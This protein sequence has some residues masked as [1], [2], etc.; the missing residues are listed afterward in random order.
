[1]ATATEDISDDD[2]GHLGLHPRCG[3]C[4]DTISRHERV[5][6]LFGNHYS[7]SYRGR[8][9]IFAFA[10][11]GHT[12]TRVNGCLL[13]RYPDSRRCAAS[14]EF[15]PIHFDCF[16]IFRQQCSVSASVAMQR[17]WIVASWRNPWRGARPVHLTAPMVDKD[18]LGTISGFCGLPRLCTLP[19]E[20]LEMIRQ[21]SEHS[22]LWRCIPALQL[23]D[24]VSATEPEPLLTVPLQEVHFW[25]RG[26]KLILDSDG[27]SKVERLPGP[28]SYTGECTSR[29][30]FIVQ[31]EASVSQ[32]VVRLKDGRL[33]L[34]R[35]AGLRTLLIWNTPAPPSLA[36]CKAYPADLPSCH[37]IHAVEMDAM[38]GIT[39]F[40]SGGQLFGIHPHRRSEESCG[41][42]TFD[43][44][45]PNRLRRALLAGDVI[46]GLQPKGEVV[47]DRYLAASTHLK[48]LYGEPRE[49]RPALL[50]DVLS[51]LVSYEQDNGYCRG[52]LFRYQNGGSR[53]VGQCRRLVDPAESVVRPVQLCFRITS[54][55]WRWNRMVCSVRVRFEE[56]ARTNHAEQDSDGW[57]SRPMK[58]LLKFWFTRESSFLIV[59]E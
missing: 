17:L 2:G 53:A 34:E 59:E 5:I 11:P 37:V 14:P 31:D 3:I 27:I 32:V 25:E 22:L 55:S 4:A 52:I 20:L 24:N 50:C 29:T 57:E 1:M 38:E 26:G 30:A 7:T 33:R 41:K 35:P 13:C 12:I 19:L 49:G 48:M 46:I 28:P 58:G 16:E 45:F 15:A 40:F 51:T 23:A 54:S 39:F 36:L 8:T 43:R 6:A 21:Y 44:D 56:G 42:D 18:T 9:R 47:K 10:Q